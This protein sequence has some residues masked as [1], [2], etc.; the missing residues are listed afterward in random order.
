MRNNLVFSLDNGVRIGFEY[1]HMK[2]I[3]PP[4]PLSE[5]EPEFPC[6]LNHK[7]TGWYRYVT[8][9]LVGF[10]RDDYLR[11]GYTHWCPDS[12]TAPE[13]VPEGMAIDA[14][15]EWLHHNNQG[16]SDPAS[17]TPASETPSVHNVCLNWDNTG[18]YTKQVV[19]L[20]DYRQLERELAEAT[21][22]LDTAKRSI[23]NAHKAM[24]ESGLIMDRE[25]SHQGLT[26]RIKSIIARSRPTAEQIEACA[27]ALTNDV[28][29]GRPDNPFFSWKVHFTE[30]LTRHFNPEKK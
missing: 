29:G 28:L 3:Q 25:K 8:G 5:R 27:D 1:T 30:A 22:A 18:D 16:P 13:V 11:M 4:I 14:P 23:E 9:A 12:P 15:T 19:S 6:W 26:P 24:D 7:E 20:D 10:N 2:N 17:R 21:F